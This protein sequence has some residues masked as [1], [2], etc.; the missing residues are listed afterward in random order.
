MGGK[1]KK[2]KKKKN[3]RNVKRKNGDPL[4]TFSK[5]IGNMYQA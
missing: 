5:L 2:E 1:R 3:G 4:T